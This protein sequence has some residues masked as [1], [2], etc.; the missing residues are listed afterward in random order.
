[1]LIDAIISILTCSMRRRQIRYQPPFSRLLF[2]NYTKWA[3]LNIFTT[4]IVSA[5]NQPV[6][7]SFLF[8]VSIDNC[9][10]TSCGHNISPC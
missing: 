3:Y 6:Q 2:A 1:M 7:S 10:L 9:V 5:D 4:S 8:H